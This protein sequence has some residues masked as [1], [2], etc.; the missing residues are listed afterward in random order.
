MPGDRDR[1][2]WTSATPPNHPVSTEAGE[3]HSAYRD[4]AV[5]S[6]Y[7][8]ATKRYT[9]TLK[10][11][12]AIRALPLPPREDEFDATVG[13]GA[14]GRVMVAYGDCPTGGRCG[15]YGFDPERN[16]SELLHA[17]TRRGV[18]PESPLPRHATFYEGHE[19]T[20]LYNPSFL[21]FQSP[22]PFLFVRHTV[23]SDWKFFLDDPDWLDRWARHF[24][25][26]ATGALAQEL[27]HLPWRVGRQ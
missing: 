6:A 8:D 9:L 10:H 18:L 23:L 24:R 7:D 17:S 1:T 26:S 2:S 4:A 16:V 5:W 14:G 22:V 21:P 13:R 11:G 20:A 27:R 12:D 3:L 25:P 15:V 19:G